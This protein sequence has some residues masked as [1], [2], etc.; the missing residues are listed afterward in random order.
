MTTDIFQQIYRVVRTR[1][2]QCIFGVLCSLGSYALQTEHTDPLVRG[3][4][5]HFE[6]EMTRDRSESINGLADWALVIA[7]HCFHVS[8]AIVH[9]A[10]AA[11]FCARIAYWDRLGAVPSRE[12]F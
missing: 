9:F 12:I 7:T 10:V 4:S 6:D 1:K 2:L 5:C 11:M 3:K 8:S